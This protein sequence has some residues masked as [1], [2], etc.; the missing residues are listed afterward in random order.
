[1]LTH[2]LIVDNQCGISVAPD[3]KEELIRAMRELAEKTG[4]EQKEMGSNSREYAKAHLTRDV[5]LEMVVNK[6]H[7]ILN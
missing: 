2:R 4:E 7:N 5:N 1:M 3:S 6:I